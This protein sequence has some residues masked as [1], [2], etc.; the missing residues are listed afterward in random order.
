MPAPWVFGLLDRQLHGE[1]GGDLTDVMFAVDHRGDLAFALDGRLVFDLIGAVFD[2]IQIGI[3]A[4]H[5]VAGV[6]AQLA[7]H[8]QFSDQIGVVFRHAAGGKKLVAEAEKLLV[9]DFGHW[10]S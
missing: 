6:A 10:V 9:I 8:Q 2:P 1:V 4:N 7:A 3:D 5:A